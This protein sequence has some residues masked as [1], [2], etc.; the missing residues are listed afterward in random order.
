MKVILVSDIFGINDSF[1][2]IQSFLQ[3]LDYEVYTLTPYLENKKIFLNEKEA[4]ETFIKECGHEKYYKKL[5]NLQEN[6]QPLYIISFSAGASASWLLSSKALNNCKKI[7]CFY[8]TSIRNNYNIKTLS[9]IKVFFAQQEKTYNVKNI[10]SKIKNKKNTKSEIMP[11][12][13]GFMNKQTCNNNE[14]FLFGLELIKKE[15]QN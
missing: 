2:E 1:L 12:S 14:E 9:K 4:Y 3:N 15:L 10:L 6:I 5:E 11:Y 8:P 7:L 13:H